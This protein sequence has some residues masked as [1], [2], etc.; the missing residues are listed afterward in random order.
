[1]PDPK[2]PPP[3]NGEAIAPSVEARLREGVADWILGA[4][5]ATFL[6]MLSVVRRCL[7]LFRSCD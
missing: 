3:T 7:G 6:A 4:L 1:M 5:L 2:Q